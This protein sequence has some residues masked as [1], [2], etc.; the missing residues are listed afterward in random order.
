MDKKYELYEIAEAGNIKV[1]EG[2]L[3]EIAG[4][5]DETLEAEAEAAKE[6]GAKE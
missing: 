1:T 4:Y 5:V 3:A 6:D 2:A